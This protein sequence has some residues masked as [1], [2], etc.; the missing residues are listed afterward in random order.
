MAGIGL[1][2]LPRL[3][4]DI[5]DGRAGNLHRIQRGTVLGLCAQSKEGVLSA[6]Y[7]YIGGSWRASVNTKGRQR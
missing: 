6:R 5:G 4:H 7:V 1:T 2:R 3:M